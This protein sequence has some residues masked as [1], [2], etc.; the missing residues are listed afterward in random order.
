L[1]DSAASAGCEELRGWFK[2]TAKNAPAA[3]FYCRNGFRA[4]ETDEEQGTLWSLPLAD[5]ALSCP[6]WIR[7]KAHEQEPARE[8]SY[9]R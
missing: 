9:S 2:P 4:V 6:E 7:L 8:L 1:A 5:S 3:D